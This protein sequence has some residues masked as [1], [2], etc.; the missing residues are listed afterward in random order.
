MKRVDLP[1]REDWREKAEAVG[2]GFHE[3]Y[4]EPYWLDGAAYLFTLAE[5]EDRIEDPTA[6]CHAL[7]MELVAEVVERPDLLSRLAIPEPCHDLVRRSWEEGDRHLYGRFDFAYTGGAGANGDA[8]LLEYNADTPTSVFEAAYFQHEWLRDRIADGWLPPDAAGTDQFN[9][10]HERLVEAFGAF[11]AQWQGGPIFHFACATA[12]DE[13]R[14]TVGYLMDCAVQAGHACE[15]LDIAEIGIDADGR[16]TDTADRVIERCFKLYPWEDMMR[17]D[18]ARHLA[19]GIFVEPAWKAILSNKGMLPL[20]WE[21]HEGHPN[22]LPAFFADDPRLPDLW[23]DE[24]ERAVSKPFHSREGENVVLL[25][26]GRPVEETAGDYGDGPRVVQAHA[27]LFEADTAAGP[28]HAVIG[29]WVVGDHACGMGLRE[30]G[31]RI[32]RDLSRFVP[33]AI[34]DDVG[35]VAAMLASHGEGD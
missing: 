13:D 17:E 30:D 26:R 11:P 21:R 22:L 12:N 24:L 35:E 1:E 14:G 6:A 10:I 8:R 5:V 20:L 4:G 25:E 3:M 28:V 32:T 16:F 29:S 19:P 15:L 2:F 23:R 33:H 18:F 34:V 31:G 9:S 27:P 7:C